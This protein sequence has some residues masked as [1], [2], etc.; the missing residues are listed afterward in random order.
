MRKTIK[1]NVPKA[2]RI[3]MAEKDI[4]RQEDLAIRMGLAPSQVS[5]LLGGRISCLPY[6]E[7]FADALDVPPSEIVLTAERVS[8]RR[9]AA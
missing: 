6:L 7:K 5:R 4:R 2:I 9:P 1:L 8:E 3:L